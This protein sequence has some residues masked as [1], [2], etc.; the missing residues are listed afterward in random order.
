MQ[1]RVLVI[2]LPHAT[3]RRASIRRQLSEQG[4]EFEFIDAVYGKELPAE[5]LDRI[6]RPLLRHYRRPFSPNEVGCYASHGKAY[7]KIAEEQIPL[8]L[9][10]EDDALLKSDLNQLFA[11][12]DKFTTPWELIN[13]GSV[14]GKRRYAFEVETRDGLSLIEY[15]HKEVGAHAYLVT[16]AAGEKLHRDWQSPYRANDVQLTFT[17]RN[18]I[19]GYY[20]LLPNQ[21]FVAPGLPSDITAERDAVNTRTATVRAKFNPGYILSSLAISLHWTRLQWLAR[22]RYW[23]G[24]LRRPDDSL[25]D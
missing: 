24:R 7:R 8:A 15:P 20:Y 19:R 17:W 12:I 14:P 3:E 2:S 13:I 10:L 9:I 21:V 5:A 23:R 6:N 22:L 16:R 1:P 25:F 18:N 4:I 11:T